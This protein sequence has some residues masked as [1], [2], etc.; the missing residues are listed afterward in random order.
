MGE[1]LQKIGA[2]GANLAFCMAGSENQPPFA[3][4]TAFLASLVNLVSDFAILEPFC[5]TKRSYAIAFPCLYRP[6]L[7]TA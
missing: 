3:P 7:Y 2:Y 5:L 1:N 4:L 6:G